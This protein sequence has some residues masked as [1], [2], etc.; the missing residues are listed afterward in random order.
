MRNPTWLFAWLTRAAPRI[1]ASPTKDYLDRCLCPFLLRHLP[2]RRVVV[3][4]ILRR[5]RAFL[6][7]ASL[8]I[9]IRGGQVQWHCNLH[10]RL[11]LVPTFAI[12]SG[13]RFARAKA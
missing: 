11:G 10:I 7:A 4:L 12:L 1:S 6:T 8:F 9:L 5:V 2:A 3:R 13:R